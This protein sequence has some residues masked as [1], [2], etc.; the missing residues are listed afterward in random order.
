MK[1]KLLTAFLKFFE[2]R[3]NSYP[4]ITKPEEVLKPQVTLIMRAFDI[5]KVNRTKHKIDIDVLFKDVKVK[6]GRWFDLGEYTCCITLTADGGIYT[7]YYENIHD[8]YG[9]I[10]EVEANHP[11]I[12]KGKA[13][14]GSFQ[15]PIMNAFHNLNFMGG[16]AQIK[17]YLNSY[18]GRSTYAAASYYRQE[19]FAP[20]REQRREVF[21]TDWAPRILVR[22][23]KAF[24]EDDKVLKLY[25]NKASESLEI[26]RF[27]GL[28]S[29]KAY[30]NVYLI[31][32][33]YNFFNKEV[34]VYSCFLI[35]Q[36]YWKK[37]P[38]MDTINSVLNHYRYK[39]ENNIAVYC[40]NKG[41]EKEEKE[42]T[43]YLN[44]IRD[45][46]TH[47]RALKYARGGSFWADK[48]G[49]SSY[50][51]VLSIND[52]LSG[53]MADIST[54]LSTLTSTTGSYSSDFN[55]EE[56]TLVK[57]TD[58]FIDKDKYLQHFYGKIK[59]SLDIFDYSVIQATPVEEVCELLTPILSQ[60]KDTRRVIMTYQLRR[61]ERKFN[62]TF[63]EVRNEIN[64]ITPGSEAHQLSFES[65]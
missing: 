60:I 27:T 32:H 44:I 1:R 28:F 41:M 7:R 20:N 9:S 57:Y 35:V 16:L 65:I 31:N 45:V 63:M 42:W 15:S 23:L 37:M 14:Y 12:N 11:H 47:W 61:F 53:K 18:N 17:A 22:H 25:T 6:C 36:S 59:S 38:K 8:I 51:R 49:I 55:P 33:I 24:S 34:P 10:H 39:C 3:K 62:K 50:N 56:T 54:K 19:I 13:C 21:G 2:W 58:K 48:F 43:D 26:N 30:N 46:Q 52:D 4:D 29:Q 40:A 5:T 64:S